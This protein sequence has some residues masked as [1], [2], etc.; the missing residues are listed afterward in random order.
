MLTLKGCTRCGGDVY[1]ERDQ[2]G[3]AEYCLQC[4]RAVDS[5]ERQHKLDNRTLASFFGPIRQR[6]NQ[7]IQIN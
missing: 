4:G 1:T 2:Y 6:P 7:E 3:P 5:D